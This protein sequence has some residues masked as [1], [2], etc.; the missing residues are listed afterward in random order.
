MSLRRLVLPCIAAAMCALVLTAC[1]KSRLPDASP[2]PRTERQSSAS[3]GHKAGPSP[4]G[5]FRPYIVAGKRYHPLAKADGFRQEGLASWYGKKFHGRKTSNGERYNM[6]DMTCAHK[7]LPMN[8]VVRVTNKTNGK[9]AVFRVNDRGPFVQSRIVDLSYTGAKRL[10]V[11]KPGTAPVVLEAIGMAG[12]STISVS[13]S[14]A[15]GR[16]YIQVGSFTVRS[17]AERLRAALKDRGYTQ[18]RIQRAEISGQTYWRVQA[19]VFAGMDKAKLAHARLKSRY[20]GSFVL[21]D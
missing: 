14:V 16:Y 2:L 6:Y 1:G 11:V 9:S 5:T 10:G 13:R 12:D 21:T 7:I 17:N 18:S 15:T 19:G 4:K 20:P 8:T 3:H